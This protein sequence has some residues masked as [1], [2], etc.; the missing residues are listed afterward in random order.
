MCRRSRLEFKGWQTF[1]RSPEPILVRREGHAKRDPAAQVAAVISSSLKHGGHARRVD[2]N[3]NHGHRSRER[4]LHARE[5]G[6]ASTAGQHLVWL[7]LALR[8]AARAGDAPSRRPDCRRTR[9]RRR[10]CPKCISSIDSTRGRRSRDASD[11]D[12]EAT[13]HR[14][15]N[16]GGGRAP[17][18]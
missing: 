11:G 3:D 12:E 6:R 15:V 17:R 5:W 13:E 8:Q 14:K 7:R 2:A 18:R 4:S 1:H 10:A 9:K 16:E